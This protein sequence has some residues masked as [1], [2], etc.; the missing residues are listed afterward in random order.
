MR[1]ESRRGP[2]KKKDKKNVLQLGKLLFL[3]ANFS[4]HL[5]FCTS[6]MIAAYDYDYSMKI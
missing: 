3:L 5:F 4:L 1:F 2:K 6:K